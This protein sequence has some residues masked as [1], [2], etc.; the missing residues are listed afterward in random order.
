MSGVFTD[1]T[2]RAVLDWLT[3]HSLPP[4]WTPP[5]NTYL[6]LLVSDPTILSTMSDGANFDRTNDP[7]MSDLDEVQAAG[8]SR[9]L[10]VW[11]ASSTPATQPSQIQN[12]TQ[13]TFGAFTDSA[14]MGAPTTF[15][16]LV[17][18]SVGTS[19]QVLMTW[20]WDNPIT[21]AQNQ[22]LV[23]PVAAINMTLQ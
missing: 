10:V 5:T 18:S 2:S 14:G 19:G 15:G 12:S 6:A 9:Q 8:Y 11:G 7:Q 13:L 16:A 1:S 3:G 23:V 17:T 21:A 20:Q 4:G 22:S